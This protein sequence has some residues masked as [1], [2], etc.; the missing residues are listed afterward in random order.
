MGS[1][2]SIVFLFI[3]IFGTLLFSCQS[4]QQK[5]ETVEFSYE[6]I[7]STAHFRID[8]ASN[9][10]RLKVKNPFVGSDAEENYVFYPRD[11]AKP[12][13]VSAQHFIP[14]P[15]NSLVITSSTHLGYLK[16]LNKE[17]K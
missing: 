17:N 12:K 2:K 11:S 8:K 15:V 5:S 1:R 7:D 4:V 16:A 6:L 3:S 9:H 10:F 13:G 14:T